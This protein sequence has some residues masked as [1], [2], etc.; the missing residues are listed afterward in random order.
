MGIELRGNLARIAFT[1]WS[2]ASGEKK[3]R[4]VCYD[5]L[6]EFV[7]EIRA[8]GIDRA[9]VLVLRC[10]GAGPGIGLLEDYLQKLGAEGE[11]LMILADFQLPAVPGICFVYVETG[12]D[13]GREPFFLMQDGDTV[14]MDPKEGALYLY[15][16]DEELGYRSYGQKR[17]RGVSA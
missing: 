17:K 2:E 12:G 6:E 3:G 13:S 9:A 4:V 8:G 1:E 10:G 15:A 11:P 7:N 16:A 14:R 5:D